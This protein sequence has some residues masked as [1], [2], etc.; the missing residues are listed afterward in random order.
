MFEVDSCSQLWWR[1]KPFFIVFT[2]KSEQKGALTGYH[3][4][5]FLTDTASQCFTATLQLAGAALR[6]QSWLMGDRGGWQKNEHVWWEMRS[7]LPLLVFSSLFLL[8]V[9]RHR[10]DSHLRVYRVLNEDV[11]DKYLSN[12]IKYIQDHF[13]VFL[14]RWGVSYCYW[15]TDWKIQVRKTNQRRSL[16]TNQQPAGCPRA[17]SLVELLSELGG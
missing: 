14:N 11:L 10:K 6:G 4:S 13:P 12:T 3:D 2:V 17:A 16:P 7:I 15:K 8:S 1:W 5:L 9:E